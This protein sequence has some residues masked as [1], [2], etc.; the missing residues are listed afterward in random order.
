MGMQTRVAP[1]RTPAVGVWLTIAG[2]GI[3]TMA[4]ILYVTGTSRAV[5]VWATP[6]GLAGVAFGMATLRGLAVPRWALL[7][8]G[9]M[10]ALLVT[11]GIATWIYAAAHQPIAT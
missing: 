7:A 5:A 11:L 8:L 10:V 1:T 6:V 2:L 3:L 9:A 4:S